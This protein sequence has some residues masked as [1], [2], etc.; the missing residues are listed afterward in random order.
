[1][2]F[3]KEYEQI[4]FSGGSRFARTINSMF[5][6]IRNQNIFILLFGEKKSD[7]LPIFAANQARYF[8]IKPSYFH[9]TG[10]LYSISSLSDVTVSLDLFSS[11][12]LKKS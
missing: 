4:V 1:M 12:G 11:Q 9:S 10:D 5:G 2:H 7:I 8:L 6:S 3:A